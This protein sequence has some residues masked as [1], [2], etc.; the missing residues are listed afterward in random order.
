MSE[1]VKT[2]FPLSVSK[3]PIAPMRLR[4]PRAPRSSPQHSVQRGT[5]HLV[6]IQPGDRLC[7]ELFFA[8]ESQS[9][10]TLRTEGHIANR[11]T[12]S[13]HKLRTEETPPT[14]RKPQCRTEGHM[15]AIHLGATSV[16]RNP[17]EV[18]RFPKSPDQRRTMPS[19]KG[20]T[21]GASWGL[22]VSRL[23]VL[24]LKTNS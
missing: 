16:I 12:L 3:V 14:T 10:Y 2:H 9:K 17:R 24:G 18:K 4:R 11:D 20:L 1:T 19:R 5:C 15:P 23:H 13:M 6:V 22:E 21:E 8:L 7:E